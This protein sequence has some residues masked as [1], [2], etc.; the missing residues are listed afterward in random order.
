VNGSAITLSS[1]TSR[2][3]LGTISILV[4][5]FLI[6]PVII[7]VPVSF[8]SD[9]FLSFPP[10][11]FSL[12]WYE[13]LFTRNDWLASGWLS[14]WI[15]LVVTLVSTVLGTAAAYGL[16][17]SSFPGKRIVIGFMLSPLIIP[18]IIVAIGVY[19]FYAKMQ[20]VGSA[21]AIA[22]AH[23][24]LAV[25]FVVVNV[26]AS[27]SGFDRRLEQAA[28]NLGAGDFTTFRL[29]TLPLIRPG[30]LAGA[31]FAFITSFDELIVALFVAGPSQVTLPLRMW[32][33]MKSSIDPTIA[34]VSVLAIIVSVLLFSS[35]ALLQARVNRMV[36][37]GKA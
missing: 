8:S 16:V 19:F 32:E 9:S 30:I 10:P 1:R 17:R 27:L 23:T 12:R 7:I 25:P 4:C 35:A 36:A 15:A 26:S 21:L 11:G 6:F 28:Q 37:A 5:L 2:I 31:L 22:M 18:G 14:I 3:V 34:A 29:V 33:S 13:R 24:A 20:L